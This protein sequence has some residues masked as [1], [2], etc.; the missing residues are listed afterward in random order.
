MA[1]HAPQMRIGTKRLVDRAQQ[2]GAAIVLIDTTGLVT[3]S[4]GFQ[5]KLSKIKLIRP[6]QLHAHL[7]TL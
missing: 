3:S 1:K 7:N 6:A 2:A 5:L 4:F